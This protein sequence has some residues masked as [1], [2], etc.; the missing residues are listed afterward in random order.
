MKL[1]KIYLDLQA[2][3]IKIAYLTFLNLFLRDIVDVNNISRQL[4]QKRK[5]ISILNKAD[6]ALTIHEIC[7]KLRLSVPTGTRM[8]NFI[9]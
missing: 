8:I 3:K 4:I 6:Q 1:I 9:S 7:K 5:I 2:Y